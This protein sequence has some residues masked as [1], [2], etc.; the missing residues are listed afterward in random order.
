M[1]QAE[2]LEPLDA[3]RLGVL[4][5][6]VQVAVERAEQTYQEEELSA[7]LLPLLARH[8]LGVEAGVELAFQEREVAELADAED[9]T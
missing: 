3:Q 7:G 5:E 9:W 1:P 6:L 4:L 8:W 2:L